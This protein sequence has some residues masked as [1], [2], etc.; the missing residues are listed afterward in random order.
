MVSIPLVVGVNH[1]SAP[2]ELRERLALGEDQFSGVLG[3]LRGS[4]QAAILST[5][6]RIELYAVSSGDGGLHDL[7]R[8]FGSWGT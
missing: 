3:S 6:N 8:F 2:V 5:C 1:L 4:F 7:R